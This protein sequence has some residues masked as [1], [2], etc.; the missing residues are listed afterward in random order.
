MMRIKRASLAFASIVPLLTVGTSVCAGA[1]SAAPFASA[2]AH[3]S[4]SASDL[5]VVTVSGS[6]ATFQPNQLTTTARWTSGT[7]CT[8][9]VESFTVKNTTSATQTLTNDGSSFGAVASGATTGVCASK[10]LAGKTETIG[11]TSNAK[12]TLTVVLAGSSSIGQAILKAASSQSGLPYCFAGGNPQGP[13]HGKGNIDG[14]TQCGKKSIVGFD[15][16]GL[17]LYAVYQATGI[18]LPHG[19]GQEDDGG[20]LITNP[21]IS[22]LE[23]GDLLLFGSSPS[24]YQHTAIYAGNGKMWDANVAGAPYPD[25]VHERTVSWE[26]ASPEYPLVGAVRF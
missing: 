2:V 16:T 6:P 26:T 25:G 13:T 18:K 1:L 15:C 17:T 23:V 11:L 5:P 22:Q 8:A 3:A 10:T 4:R 20:T 21:S 12:A 7:A 9:S 24:D 14:A 19:Q